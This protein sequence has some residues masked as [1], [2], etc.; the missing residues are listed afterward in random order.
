MKSLFFNSS[1]P[2][3]G[4]ELIQVLMHQNPDI[5]ASPTS[6]LLEF[7]F[8]ARSNMELPEVKSQPTELMN[9]A[10]IEFCAGASKGYYE[11][12][13]DRPYVI[14]KSRGWGHYKE[15]A[16]QIVGGKSKMICMVRDIRDI[17]SHMEKVY[18]ANRHLPLGPDNP[19]EMQNM[20]VGQRAQHWLNSQPV[21]LAL[22][23]TLDIFQ[24][25]V[26]KDVLFVRYEDLTV[27]PDVEM[28]RIYDYLELDYFQHDYSNIK[29]EVIEDD[30]WYGPYG[31]HSVGGSLRPFKN[32]YEE[33]L[34]KEI[35]DMVYE[36]AS[37][38][39]KTFYN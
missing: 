7:L 16:D 2:Q 6:P 21:G 35:S 19:A 39:Q 38:Y 20:T 8:G 28:K 5:Y 15:W 25:G 24:R 23:R 27:Q 3:A 4:S 14:D 17:I 29:K 26:N 18:R 31:S 13:T 9:K 32:D 12:I 30:S 11:A 37:W 22:Q 1:M 33:T 34:G 10:F 36:S